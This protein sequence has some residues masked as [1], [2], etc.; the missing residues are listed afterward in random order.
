MSDGSLIVSQRARGYNDDAREVT[1]KIYCVWTRLEMES[2]TSHGSTSHESASHA[3][4]Y[5]PI[6]EPVS[7][8]KTPVDDIREN[9]AHLMQL[10]I[11]MIHLAAQVEILQA[12]VLAMSNLLNAQQEMLYNV[13]YEQKRKY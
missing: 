10:R 1:F 2:G 7:P 8:T 9:T 4:C 13:K 3:S 6:C 11:N 5:Q 12:Q